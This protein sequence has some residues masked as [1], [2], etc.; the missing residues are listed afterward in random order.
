MNA[1]DGEV[2][3][4]G[5]MSEMNVNNYPA[6]EGIKKIITKYGAK[7]KHK[8]GSAHIRNVLI[9]EFKKQKTKGVHI[10]R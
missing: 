1:G 7:Q 4:N 9:F 5:R 6:F 2:V 10:S 3:S 8:A